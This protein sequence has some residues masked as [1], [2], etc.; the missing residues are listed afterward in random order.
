MDHIATGFDSDFGNKGAVG[1]RFEM[2]GAGGV[3]TTMC[4][5]CC[6]LENGCGPDHCVERNKDFHKIA[7]NLK[8][9][10]VSY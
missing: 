4:L 9:P 3:K 6:H 5:I 1:I 10:K 8:F 2:S 7:Q